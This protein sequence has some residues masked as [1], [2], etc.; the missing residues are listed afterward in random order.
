MKSSVYLAKEVHTAVA[1]VIHTH[2]LEGNNFL[3]AAPQL[4]GMR[5][6]KNN[7]VNNISIAFS[8]TGPFRT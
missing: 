3:G 2:T 4:A 8:K 5:L 6:G 1:H 7:L